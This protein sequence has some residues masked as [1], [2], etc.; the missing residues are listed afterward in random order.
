MTSASLRGWRPSTPTHYARPVQD[1]SAVGG[2][3]GVETPDGHGV[4]VWVVSGGVHY[5]VLDSVM[6]LLVDDVVPLADIRTLMTAGSVYGATVFTAGGGLYC[7]TNSNTS[8]TMSVQVWQANN[9][10]NPTSWSVLS[11]PYSNHAGGPS[12]GIGGGQ[13]TP[14]ILDDGRWVLGCKTAD[15]PVDNSFQAWHAR[16][17]T[18][19]NTG[20][21][22]TQRLD[23]EHTNIFPRTEYMATQMAQDPVTGDLWW[24]SG[25]SVTTSDMNIMWWSADDGTNWTHGPTINSPPH[26]VSPA[27]DNG[28]NIYGLDEGGGVY[29]YDGSGDEFSDWVST[30]QNWSAPGVSL[31]STFEHTVHSTVISRGVFVFV[32]D[33]VMFIRRGGWNTGFTGT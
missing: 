19:D 17:F 14:L 23:F 15:G 13:A 22:W 30:G 12:F 2:L 18:S 1:E 16:I 28:S 10:N 11:T 3:T 33:Q 20:T 25:T 24:R 7:V 27:I 5:A 4:A 26:R 32:R 21:S 29:V 31:D 8:N 9:A 6:D